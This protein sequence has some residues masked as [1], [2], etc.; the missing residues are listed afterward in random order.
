MSGGS[1]RLLR[2]LNER[3]AMEL[4][5][6]HGP[7]TR[8][9]LE[10]LT[11]LSKASVAEVLRRLETAGLVHK[12]GSKP[13]PAGPPAQLWA[14]QGTASLVVGVDVTPQAIDVAVADLAGHV[15]GEANVRT[16]K[17]YD[18]V[19]VLSDAVATAC[20]A[21]QVTT[22]DIDQ[23]VIGMPGVVDPHTGQ[24][25][26]V[27]QVPS[28]SGFHVLN[29]VQE[30]LG[31]DHVR[32]ENDVNLV[33]LEELAQGAATGIDTFALLWIGE[34]V[35]AGLVLRGQLWRGATGR[36]GELSSVI[37]PD[38]VSR[39][40]VYDEQGGPLDGVLDPRALLRLAH[41]HDLNA[42]TPVDAVRTGFA[43]P[44]RYSG[45]LDDLVARIAVALINVVGMLDPEL[46]V[47]GGPIGQTGGDALCDL[48]AQRLGGT[49]LARTPIVTSA[50]QGNPVRAGALEFGLSFTRDRILSAGTAGR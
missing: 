45:F 19:A 18:A 46:V 4:L 41:A 47:L 25:T 13:S 1:P 14:I 20:A 8:A 48:L 26:S 44:E 33:A 16:P 31:I 32:I 10:E 2:T 6:E 29:S 12:N 43:E 22:D 24:L 27:L 15:L 3:A 39:A 11:G 5:I 17:K 23:V 38:P 40:R 42:R 35:G 34:G 21:A 7:S 30:A 9:E 50:V 36:S 49:L 28:W 37:V